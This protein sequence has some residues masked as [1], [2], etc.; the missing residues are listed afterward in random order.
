MDK[1]PT[2]YLG[3]IEGFFG[4]PW[5]WQAR[6]QHLEFLH[7]FDF[8]FFIYAPKSDPHLRRHWQEDWGTADKSQ[9]RQLRKHAQDL[10]ID[11]GIGLTPL[12][13]HLAPTGERANK[14]I[15]RL[16]EI[17]QHS[18]D[19]LCIL[20]DDMRGDMPELA[21][22]QVELTHIA[23]DYTNAKRIIFCPTYYSFD[24]VLERVFGH[25]PQ[26]YWE[27]L[28]KNLDP[29]IDIFWTGEKVCSTTYSQPHLHEVE[30]LLG[31]KPFLWDNY[32]VNDGAIKSKLLHLRAVPAGHSL[33]AEQVSGHAVNPMNQPQLSQIALASLAQ[34]YRQKT[35]YQP[36]TEQSLIMRHLLGSDFGAQLELDLPLFQ[37]KGLSHISPDQTADLCQRYQRFLPHAAAQELVDWLNG[38]YEFDPAC[39]T[40]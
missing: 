10:K 26:N 13:L 25:R 38:E 22:A 28:A 3:T 37:D 36:Q 4:K 8:N 29:S 34:A 18:P 31:R 23:A 1:S 27:D 11:F 9:L 2:K 24:P 6:L 7:Q 32:P 16:R 5:S 39:L 30:L 15:K 17:N 19:I 12:E 14:L 33:L 21:R 40:D 20:F 35:A